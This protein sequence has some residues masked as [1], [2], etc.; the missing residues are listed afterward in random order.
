MPT[1]QQLLH[2]FTLAGFNVGMYAEI[3]SDTENNESPQPAASLSGHTPSRR[4]VQKSSYPPEFHPY[5]DWEFRNRQTT[6]PDY[7]SMAYPPGPPGYDSPNSLI[8]A[9]Q[10]ESLLESQ[11]TMMKGWLN[12]FKVYLT[13]LKS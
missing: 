12:W 4:H 10:V 8:T 1:V 6:L 7:H 5:R 9:A 11:K 2:T 3:Y 13:E